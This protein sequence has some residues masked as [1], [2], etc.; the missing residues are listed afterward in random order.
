M[1]EIVEVVAP[2][3]RPADRDGLAELFAPAAVRWELPA[4]GADVAVL[5]GDFGPDLARSPGLRW[6]HCEHAGLDGSALGDALDAGVAVTSGAGRS[7]PALA[8]HA[9]LFM[10]ALSAQLPRFVRAQRRRRW[11]VAGQHELRALH[12]RTVAI[13]GTGHTGRALAERCA[14]LGMRVLGHR[15]RDEPVEGPFERVTSSAR[16]EGVEG[17]LA[18]ADFVVLAAGLNDTTAGLIGVDQLATMRPGSYLV[19]VARGGL[20]D[21]AALVAALRSGHLAGAA[22]DVT[23]QE[24]LPRRSQLWRAPNLLLTPHVTPRVADRAERARA[25]LADNVGRYREGR[26]L[27]NQ[28][29]P[30]DVYTGAPVRPDR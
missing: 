8:E 28:L 3:R 26:P 27:R 16:G 9:L 12:G 13:I 2:G 7:A 14:A 30:E 6:I 20:V 25:L 15:R 5:A 4:D 11:G 23:A 18:E 21:E 19:N 1:P 24:P 22:T 29:G 17:V 10:L